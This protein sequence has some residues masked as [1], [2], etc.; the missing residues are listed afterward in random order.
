MLFAEKGNSRRS[1]RTST[2]PDSPASLAQGDAVLR[3]Q[4]EL[5]QAK[6]ERVVAEQIGN[7]RVD[8]GLFPRHHVAPLRRVEPVIDPG[9]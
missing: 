2:A 5:R 9:N 8:P 7:H 6:L 1:Q 4:I 3:Q